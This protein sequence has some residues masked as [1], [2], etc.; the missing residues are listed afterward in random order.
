MDG[1][2]KAGIEKIGL[3]TEPIGPERVGAP[4]IPRS[5]RETKLTQLCVR[6]CCYGIPGRGP[7]RFLVR[8]GR[9]NQAVARKLK[10]TLVLSLVLHVVVL[11]R[12]G[13]FGFRNRVTP[14][15]S[16]ESVAGQSADTSEARRVG[17]AGR[18]SQNFQIRSRFLPRLPRL[19]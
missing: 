3:V 19:Q 14:L 13:A 7:V 2:K 4:E 10:R 5:R 11:P 16:V 15:T 1:V 8:S 12:R 17:E 9:S 18:A 6:G